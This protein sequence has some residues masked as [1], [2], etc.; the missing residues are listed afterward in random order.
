[1]HGDVRMFPFMSPEMIHALFGFRQREVEEDA[2]VRMSDRRGDDLIAERQPSDPTDIQHR[3]S[4]EE[5]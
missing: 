5:E 4:P 3:A 2:P 1:M